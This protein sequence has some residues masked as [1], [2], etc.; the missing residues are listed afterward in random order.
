MS[1]KQYMFVVSF[2][3]SVSRFTLEPV[4][5]WIGDPVYDFEDEQIRYLD[6][7]SEARTYDGLE[8]ILQMGLGHLNK[9]LADNNVMLDKGE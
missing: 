1:N 7:D 3:P 4:G 5:N 2:N 8:D 9:V 6:S